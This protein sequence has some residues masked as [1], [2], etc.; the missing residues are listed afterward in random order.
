MKKTIVCQRCGKLE[1]RGKSHERV[2]YKDEVFYLCVDCS[3]IAYKI[4]DA[5]INKDSDCADT[6]VSEFSSLPKAQNEILAK[7]F[8]DYKMRIGYLTNN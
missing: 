7:W 5:V 8:D 6:L 4:K 2:S 1:K 3:Q